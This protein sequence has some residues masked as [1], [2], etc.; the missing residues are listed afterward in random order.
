MTIVEWDS[1]SAH[2]L[3]NLGSWQLSRCKTEEAPD[4]LKDV[5]MF[6]AD[7]AN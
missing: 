4:W 2:D 5:R 6:L 7:A 3:Q 1:Y